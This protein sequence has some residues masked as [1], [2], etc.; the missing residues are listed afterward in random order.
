MDTQGL[1]SSLPRQSSQF[2]HPPYGTTASHYPIYPLAQG[3]REE[4]RTVLLIVDSQTDF[5]GRQIPWIV[6]QDHNLPVA[7]PVHIHA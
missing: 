5:T 2:I 6:P 7:K 1:Y 3:A 4:G